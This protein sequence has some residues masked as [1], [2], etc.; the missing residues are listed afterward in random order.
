MR[1]L[2]DDEGN[3]SRQAGMVFEVTFRWMHRIEGCVLPGGC[4]RPTHSLWDEEGRLL[5]P[6]R[7]PQAQPLAECLLLPAAGCC[8]VLI[9]CCWE[10]E[11]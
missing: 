3:L 11:S 6:L 5:E 4:E 8:L 7:D 10:L 2:K 9:R 1:N